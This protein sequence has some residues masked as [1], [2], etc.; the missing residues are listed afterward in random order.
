M[1]LK[2]LDDRI[3]VRPQEAEETTSSGIVIPDTAEKKL[4]APTVT[5]D[6]VTIAREVT[7]L[8]NP[9]EN[10]GAMLV[11]EVAIKT[12]DNA[13]DGTTTATV[14]AQSMVHEGMRNVAAGAEPLRLKRGMDA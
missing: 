2:P 6:G 4:G 8:E 3:V 11:R 10:M 1:N 9:F 13:G 5:N 7:P 14:L 12:N